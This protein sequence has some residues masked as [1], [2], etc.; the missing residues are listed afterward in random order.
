M[1]LCQDAN[2]PIRT[3]T[4]LVLARTVV[5]MK[6]EISFAETMVTKEV[7]EQADDAVWSLAN[8]DQVIHLV[9]L[10]LK[11]ARYSNAQCA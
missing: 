7:V 11:G 6:V 2:G 1:L 8:I 5:S 3:M 10:F 4:N 9:L